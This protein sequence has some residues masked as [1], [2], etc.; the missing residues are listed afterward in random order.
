MS[1]IHIVSPGLLWLVY[2]SALKMSLTFLQDGLKINA[3]YLRLLWLSDS[4]SCD[5]YYFEITA[6]SITFVCK[7]I[8]NIFLKTGWFALQL[9]YLLIRQDMTL[10]W[11][12]LVFWSVLR[13]VSV[14]YSINVKARFSLLNYTP[15]FYCFRYIGALYGRVIGLTMV[16]LFGV[17]DVEDDE[18]WAWMDPGAFALIGAAS[19]FG[20]VSRLTMSLTVIMVRCIVLNEDSVIRF[21]LH[22]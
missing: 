10:G 15:L 5:I 9:Q 11:K 13:I 16:S 1:K 21:V 18:Y 3:H 20:G 4:V 17:Q 22:S 14:Y 7:I 19:F 8:T 2:E 6:L 12:I